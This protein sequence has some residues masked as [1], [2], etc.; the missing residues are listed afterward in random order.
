MMHALRLL[1]AVSL[2][3]LTSNACMDMTDDP[4]PGDDGSRGAEC[5]YSRAFGGAGFLGQSSSTET[6]IEVDAAGNTFMAGDFRGALQ[7]NETTLLSAGELDLW[8][9][10]L[11]ERGRLEWSRSFGDQRDQTLSDLHV[12]PDGGFLITGNFGGSLDFGAVPLRAEYREIFLARFDAS[13]RHLWSRRF[14]GDEY[15]IQGAHAVTTDP[16]GNVLLLGSLEGTIDFGGVVVQSGGIFPFL[17]KFDAQGAPLWGKSFGGSVDQ[18]PVGVVTDQYNNIYVVEEA[19]SSVIDGKELR[20]DAF[21]NTL[22]A[23][24]GPGGELHWAQIFRQRG[25]AAPDSHP[26]TV[27]TAMGIDPDGNLIV[28]GMFSGYVNFG[29][30]SLSTREF[31]DYAAYIVSFDPLGNARW[32]R[33]VEDTWI[34]GIE[35]NATGEILLT[36]S[37]EGEVELGGVTLSGAGSRDVLVAGLRARDGE[38][39]WG[40]RFG[41]KDDQR[42]TG[43]AAGRDGRVLF[44]GDYSGSLDFGCD[45][46][47]STGGKDLF[48]G[49]IRP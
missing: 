24:F 17:V 35:A 44:T 16:E 2:L 15:N 48:L 6:E 40:Y 23:R 29:A 10:K 25:S 38:P 7:F 49:A 41:D 26:D 28:A 27:P 8:L 12:T 18:I 34:H 20:G 43:I 14:G 5:L 4:D 46:L 37:I 3:A 11:D 31:N 30:G 13:G 45:P 21:Y 33:A 22:V 9:A 19:K 47:R 32:S 39:L 1:G 42:G 36:G